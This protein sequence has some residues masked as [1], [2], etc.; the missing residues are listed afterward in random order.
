EIEVDQSGKLAAEEEHVVGKE[1]GVDDA[2]RQFRWPGV[3][4]M[5]KFGGEKPFKVG[6]HLVR[7]FAATVVELPP[8]IDVKR[9]GAAVLEMESGEVQPRQRLAE[10]AAV[11]R[12]WAPDPHAVEERDHCRRTAG[13]LPQD[14][15]PFVLDWLRAADSARVQ[16]LHQ[17]EKE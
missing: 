10:R 15:T 4:E 12:Q 1:V 9:V 6:L 11:R 16:V 2:V 14:L 3:F 13:D 5:R 7:P 17:G 8:P